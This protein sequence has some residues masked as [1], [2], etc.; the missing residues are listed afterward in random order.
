[1]TD[2]IPHQNDHDGLRGTDRLIL[3][4]V[5]GVNTFWLFAQ[6]TRRWPIR[7]APALWFCC[8]STP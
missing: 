4:I 2:D 7:S 1:M 5:L 8:R 6:T 3:G